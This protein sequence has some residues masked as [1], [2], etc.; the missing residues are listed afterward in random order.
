MLRRRILAMIAR[1]HP[2]S[3]RASSGP[4]FPEAKLQDVLVAINALR[5]AR[6]IEQVRHGVYRTAKRRPAPTR[7]APEMLARLMAGR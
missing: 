5:L 2:A 7:Y 1:P 6:Q 4:A 3:A